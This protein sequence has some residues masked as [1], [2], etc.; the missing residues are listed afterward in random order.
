MNRNRFQHLS[1]ILCMTLLSISCSSESPE[2]DPPP[3]KDNLRLA[4]GQLELMLKR[5]EE[6]KLNPRSL[7]EHGELILVKPGD[8]TSGFFPGNLWFMYEYSGEGKWLEAARHFTANLYEEQFN[9]TTHD[10]GFKM[11]RSYGNGYRLTSDESYRKIL[12]TAART[13]MERFNTKTGCIRSWDHHD[14][15]WQY[16]V[17]I[18][19][20]MNLEHLFFAARETGDPV[21][22]HAAVSHAEKTIETH[23]RSD[24]STYHVVDYDTITGK[25]LK[26]NTHQG[27]DDGSV[28]ARGQAWALYGFVMIY[29]ETGIE[30]FLQQAEKIAEFILNHENLPDDMIPYWDFDHPDIPDTYRDASAASITCSALYELS[31]LSKNKDNNYF[32]TADRIL[33]TLSSPAY[34]ASPGKNGGFILKHGVGNLP[35]NTEIDV[36]LIYSDYYF[37]EAC[38]RRLRITGK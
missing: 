8:W 4:G 34:L 18:D 20:L 21:F 22:Y 37:I 10:M 36:P 12:I 1:L 23:F 2:I 31:T 13:L 25:V 15:L 19:N 30:K 32:E 11:L 9:G 24:Y 28:W 29:R 33:N 26:K 17:I 3:V 7:N 16:P 14:H 27:Y 38:L 6:S 5:L 35:S